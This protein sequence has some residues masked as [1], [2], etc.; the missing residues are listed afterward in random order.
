MKV[1]S[2]ELSIFFGKTRGLHMPDLP[3]CLFGIQG[4]TPADLASLKRIARFKFGDRESRTALQRAFTAALLSQSLPLDN[5]TVVVPPTKGPLPRPIALAGKSV[6]RELG[7]CFLDA[8]TI[9]KRKM[10]GAPSYASIVSPQGREER[11]REGISIGLGSIVTARVLLLDDT[12]ATGSTLRE[13][14]RA[15]LEVMA[16]SHRTVSLYALA[17]AKYETQNVQIEEMNNQ[18]LFWEL[19]EAVDLFNRVHILTNTASR[20]L[21]ALDGQVFLRFVAGLSVSS[22]R[23]LAGSWQAYAK[24]LPEG[25]RQR[26][27]REKLNILERWEELSGN[28]IKVIAA[29]KCHQDCSL[30]GQ[31]GI[32]FFAS[33]E[34]FDVFAKSVP[35]GS[36]GNSS[37]VIVREGRY[38]RPYR[39]LSY[40]GCWIAEIASY[41]DLESLL[42]ATM[43]VGRSQ[44]EMG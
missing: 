7:M 19:Q 11:R 43:L 21:L 33:S 14:R 32:L 27:V 4:Y 10:A 3:R 17:Y 35:P 41:P 40:A 38:L 37:L 22:R 18:L 34:E 6:A 5:C 23:R 31:N 13:Y 42:L 30:D 39:Y 26:Q 24:L 25:G 16:A 15:V 1:A 2:M 29:G 9:E 12:V 8:R 36:L 28:P 44:W 20:V